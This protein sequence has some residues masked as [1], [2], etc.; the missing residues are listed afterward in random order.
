[1]QRLAVHVKVPA[2]QLDHDRSISFYGLDSMAAVT[3]GCEIEEAFAIEWNS[4]LLFTGDQSL[5]QLSVRIAAA[6]AQPAI[7]LSRIRAS[8]TDGLIL[9][10]VPNNKPEPN[11]KPQTS[12]LSVSQAESPAQFLATGK[13]GVCEPNGKRSPAGAKPRLVLGARK[14]GEH[15][16]RTSVNPELGRVLAQMAM[17]KTFVRGEGCWLWDENGRRYLDFLAQY[18]A[19]PFGFNPPRIWAALEAVRQSAEPS[20]TQPS[21]LNAAGELA[22]RLLEAA[23]PGMAY[24]TFAN[25]GAEAVE[26]AIK[27]ARSTTGRHGILAANN[28]FHGKTLGAL[29]AT[30]KEKYQ[31]HFGAPVPG[32]EYVPY[33]N[34]EALRKMLSTRKFAGFI[35]EPVQGEGGIVE[36]PVGYLRSAR[37]ACREAGTL[38]IA[39]EIQTGIGRTGAM[40]VCCELG[41]TPDIMTVAKALGGGLVPIGAC[42]A[43]SAAYNEYFALKHTS[44]FAGNTLACR[45]GLATLNWL[46]END[47]ALLKDVAENGRRLKAG[48]LELQR[49]Y[50]SVIAEIRGRGY[51]LGLRFGLNRYSVEDGL[52]GYLGEQ[53]EFTF[54]VVG[55][56]LHFEGV[57]V[58]CTLNQGGILR[59]EPPLTATWKECQ[60]F[61]SAL[62]RVLVILEKRD[63][64]QLTAQISGLRFPDR[65]ASPNGNRPTTRAYEPKRGRIAEPQVGDGRFAF[66]VHPLAWKD[67][68]DLDRTLTALTN[69]QLATL[70]SAMADN[71]DPFV[72][73]QTRV[74]GKNGKAAFGE[75]ILV[76]RRAEELKSMPQAQALDEIHK[77]VALGA[78]R[79]ANIIGLGAYTSVVT[80]GGLS[81]KGLP[82]PALTTGNSY[83][84]VAARDTIRLAAA[85]KG[86]LLPNRSV[87]IL[88][89]AGSIG[90]AT[91]IL[92]SCDIGRLVLLGN[93]A[94]PDE[95]RQRLL[96]V[97]GRIVWAR[98]Q[99]DEG[100]QPLPGSVASWARELDFYVPARPDRATLARLGEELIRRSGSVVVSVDAAGMLPEVDLIVSCTSSTEHIVR[101]EWLRSRV[102]VC[103]VSRPSNIAADVGLNRPDVMILNGGV[104][105][106]PGNASLGINASLGHGLSYACMAETMMLAME[107]RYEDTSLGFDLAP[108]RVIEM[109]RLANQLGFEAVLD[110]KARSEGGKYCEVPRVLAKAASF[111][112]VGT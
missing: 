45:A 80:R 34:L 52:L 1:V 7:L 22:G 47:H 98:R 72:I 63:T 4:D 55:H 28:G 16:F 35:V 58:G 74:V 104:V 56:L 65:P 32:F 5:R 44:T 70:S 43:T 103:D 101:E 94:H 93:P 40:F 66:L 31:R 12:F 99:S 6:A 85:E 41:I 19:L 59:I 17:D 54:L 51:L 49:R 53:D 61:L 73:G 78:K 64:A 57:R 91:A 21:Y 36:P 15:P 62:E 48:L 88:G 23:P 83:T 100:P 67:Y 10:A 38:F 112:A 109:E 106:M 97:A 102:V 89:A 71:F 95:S 107:K 90:D 69:D 77:G 105:R 42:V 30:D 11:G 24:V 87:A 60:V 26:A 25:S 27:M 9:E 86:W 75:F 29:S 50:P 2:H 79:G 3:L 108:D 82:V 68:G 111:T 8:E 37:K 33:G 92:L 18:G 96:Q 14:N 76:P 13:S 81:L 110:H 46:E 39:D 20:F 84:A